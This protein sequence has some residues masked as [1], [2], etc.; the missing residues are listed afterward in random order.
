MTDKTC[1]RPGC[2]KK[3]RSNNTSGK[4]STGCR[5]PEAAPSQRAA[6]VEGTV[7]ASQTAPVA[8]VSRGAPAPT[9]GDEV[10]LTPLA[11]F[12]M[13]AEALGKDP[14]AILNEFAGAWLEA[15]AE[16]LEEA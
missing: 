1:S 9:S 5:S 12:R 10:S 11:K 6:D 4:C 7:K 13:V 8:K 2:D 3:L 15:L 14:A 16:K